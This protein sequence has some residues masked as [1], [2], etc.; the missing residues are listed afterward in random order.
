MLL[1]TLIP[2]S[3]TLFESLVILD[4][5]YYSKFDFNIIYLTLSNYILTYALIIIL[6]R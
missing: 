4:A 1:L 2:Y 5:D 6:Q 3:I